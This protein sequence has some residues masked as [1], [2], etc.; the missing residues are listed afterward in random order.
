[1]PLASPA[2]NEYGGG[3]EARRR[4]QKDLLLPPAGA[5][6][7]GHVTRRNRAGSGWSAPNQA[8]MR[9]GLRSW[10]SE[11]IVTHKSK[12]VNTLSTAERR[13]ETV[14][15]S[16]ITVFARTG[17]L[18]T[19]ISD[20]AEH[21]RIS[22]AYVFK[23]FPAK[24]SLFVAAL[25]RCFE[26]IEKALAEGADNAPTQD[27]ADVLYAMGG[28]YAELIADRDV[29]MMQVHAQSAADVPEI[30]IGMRRGLARVT[31][32]ATDRSG[33]TRA[34]VQRFMA[35][36][37]LCHLITTLGL[38]TVDDAWSAILTDGIRHPSPERR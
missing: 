10:P 28:A 34:Q 27:P 26:R 23:L 2:G 24:V 22:P 36:G 6:Q 14:I 32:F 15:A 4:R 35:F 11:C 9:N 5:R 38:D 20:I 3:A 8:A 7:A 21:A 19:P 13:R 37:Q 1:M 16:A 30:R 12:H 17:Y 33:G 25:D 29:L 31:T 18:G